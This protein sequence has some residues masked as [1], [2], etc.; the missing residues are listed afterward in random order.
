MRKKVSCQDVQA[1]I[2]SHENA[3]LM[4]VSEGCPYCDQ[5]LDKLDDLGLRYDTLVVN[6]DACMGEIDKIL[7]W[8]ATPMI[9]HFRNSEEVRRGVGVDGILG[10]DDESA[11]AGDSAG[12]VGEEVTEEDQPEEVPE[13]PEAPP[14]RPSN[15]AAAVNRQEETGEGSDAP[16]AG[17]NASA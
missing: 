2:N 17:T 16:M 3:Y 6:T 9:A 4:L 12:A 1:H 8:P 5:V 10:F 11:S 13:P 15:G 14:A 7:D